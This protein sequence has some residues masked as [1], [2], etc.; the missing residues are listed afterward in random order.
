[1]LVSG[2]KW[3]EGRGGSCR[4]GTTGC[5]GAPA[6]VESSACVTLYL[7]TVKRDQGIERDTHPDLLPL[8]GRAASD[9]ARF[10]VATYSKMCLTD[11]PYEEGVLNSAEFVPG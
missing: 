8:N 2:L 3:G 5:T 9:T 6:C 10:R 4:D 11:E 1:M 7:S